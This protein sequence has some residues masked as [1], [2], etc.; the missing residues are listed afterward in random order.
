MRPHRYLAS[1]CAAAGL[2]L[3]SL[4]PAA[5]ATA[6]TSAPVI[7]ESFTLL[8]C[9]SKPRTTLQIEGCAEHRVV[10]L[11]RTI[12]SLNARVFAKL[13]RSGRAAF[14]RANTAWVSYR[15]GA[16]AAQASIYSGGSI[17]PVA[18]ANCLVSIDGSHVSELKTML[19]ALEPAG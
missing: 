18:D 10:A 19:T 11:D 13:S 7:H 15:N 6:V 16:C 1:G 9:P 8:R 3:G 4:S 14:I 2:A 17:Q 5:G 12:D